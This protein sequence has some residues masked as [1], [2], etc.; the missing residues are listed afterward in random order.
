MFTKCWLCVN[1]D[2]HPYSA[3]GDVKT[4]RLNCSFSCVKVVDKKCQLISQLCISCCWSWHC[5]SWATFVSLAETGCE[6]Q[7]RKGYDLEA[8]ATW[9]CLRAISN[10]HLLALFDSS[11]RP[12]TPRASCSS[13]VMAKTIYQLKWRMAKWLP[14]MTSDQA[15]L[16]Y[17]QH[18]IHSRITMME[19]G[20]R[21]SWAG[22]RM[23][24]Y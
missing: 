1:R 22:D 13:W 2:V 15:Q 14:D 12:S 4:I 11:S 20:I 21:C 6:N 23:M 19:S 3:T 17:H 5:N 18:R 7:H 8:M 9:S 16:C 24:D 10:R